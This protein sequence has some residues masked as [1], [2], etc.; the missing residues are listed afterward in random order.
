MPPRWVNRANAAGLIREFRKLTQ[1]ADTPQPEVPFTG[2]FSRY[3]GSQIARKDN[4][5]AQHELQA[6]L[7][8]SEKIGVALS[9]CANPLSA[10]GAQRLPEIERMLR[11]TIVAR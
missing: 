6:A 3:R 4:A 2:K 9:E 1:E 5:V 10:R 11:N 8:N 7:G